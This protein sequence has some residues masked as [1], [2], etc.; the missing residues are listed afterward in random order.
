MANDLNKA[1]LVGRLT[2]EPEYRIVN[3][4]PV[5]N[6]SVANNRSYV[7]NNEKKEE[8]HFF[9]CVAWGKLADI[10]K[11]YAKKGQQVAI[12]GR[13][14]QSTW[15]TPEGKKNSKIRVFV[16]SLQLLGGGVH[17]DK[18]SV[19]YSEGNPEE[20][21]PSIGNIQDEDDTVF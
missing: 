18:E 7:S 5:V 9:D 12:E 15:E 20:Y 8:T 19:S 1:I 21:S 14:Q 10:I 13:L 2:R 3:Q 4:S 17:T 11:H 16:E 6:F